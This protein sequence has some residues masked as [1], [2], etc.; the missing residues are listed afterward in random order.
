MLHYGVMGCAQ[1]LVSLYQFLFYWIIY[2]RDLQ[3]EGTKKNLAKC[4]SHPCLPVPQ[5]LFLGD[6][7]IT[8]FAHVCMP[9]S[10]YANAVWI[11]SIITAWEL[12]M[13]TLQLVSGSEFLT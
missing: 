2:P 13:H 7:N 3:F 1:A 9:T 10:C 12:E 8:H 6:I 4:P 11:R 5:V